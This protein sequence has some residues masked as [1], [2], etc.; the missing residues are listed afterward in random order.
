MGAEDL[1]AD[2]TNVDPS[3]EAPVG[4]EVGGDNPAWEPIRS[5]VDETT[6]HL[7]K[8]HLSKF[9]QE[10]QRRVQSMN[11]KFGWAGKLIESGMTPDEV[12]QATALAKQIAEDPTTVFANL[13]GYVEQYYPD[14]YAKLDWIARQ[15]AAGDPD[16]QQQLLDLGEDDPRSAEYAQRE[17]SLNEREQRLEHFFEEQEKKQLYDTFSAQIDRE[18]KAISAERPDLQDADWKEIMGYAAAQ[19]GQGRI[20]SVADSVKWFDSIANRVRTAPRPGDSAP[21]LLPLGG[22]NPASPQKVDYTKMSDADIQAM[23]AA[24]MDAKNRKS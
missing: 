20:V 22:G 24:D 1:S 5:A 13:K 17:A 11:E 9:D 18:H 15:A 4:G 16:A 2:Q 14:E 8:P 12:Q 3:T 23:I 21:S 6:Y 7:I 19:A 10:A